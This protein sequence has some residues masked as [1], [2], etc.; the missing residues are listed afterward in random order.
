MALSR[1]LLRTGLGEKVASTRRQA[2][3]AEALQVLQ[4]RQIADRTAGSFGILL[5]THLPL[6][7]SLRRTAPVPVRMFC[8]SRVCAFRE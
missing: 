1:P 3:G 7:D 5:V 8:K 2:G 4:R 6:V